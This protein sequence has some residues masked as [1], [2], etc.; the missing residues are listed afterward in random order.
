M[1]ENLRKLEEPSHGCLKIAFLMALESSQRKSRTRDMAKI[2]GRSALGRQAVA[3][4]CPDPLALGATSGTGVDTPLCIPSERE[5]LL[6]FKHHLRD[7]F[8]RLSSWNNASANSDCCHWLGVVCSNVT[9]H[10]AELHLNTTPPDPVDYPFDSE[11]YDKALDVTQVGGEINPCLADLKHLNYLNLSHNFLLGKRK[12]I[13]A[14][15]GTMISLSHL[16][17]SHTEFYGK[18]P[19]QFGNLSNLVYFDLSNVAQGTIPSQIGNVSNLS[20]LNLRGLSL[21]VENVDWLSRLSKLKYLDL[22]GS[23][24]SKAFHWLHTLQAL[25]SLMHLHLSQCTLHVPHDSQPYTLNF[26]SLL[27]LDMSDVYYPFFPKWVLGLTKAFSIELS[28]NNIQGLI[29]D[30]IQNITFLQ[31]LDLSYNSFSSSIPNSLCSL[32][33]LKFLRLQ[34]NILNGSISNVLGN[35]TSLIVLDLSS[36]GQLEGTIPTSL[37][38]QLGPNFPSWILSQNKLQYLEMSNAGIFDSIPSCTNHLSSKLPYLSNDVE[39]L[40]LSS[41]ALS[42]S[43]HEFLC[44][45]QY[46]QM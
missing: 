14:F 30:G 11:G 12:P 13:P 1:R 5:T 41:N 44:K 32:H 23:N 27:T 6:K 7:P 22:R 34:Q 37:E 15:L 29:P 38:W 4:V 9:A 25:P 36:N 18:I 2:V 19:P 16:D 3:S 8:N 45:N 35:L 28:G 24:L 20:Y 46:K 17:L 40:D 10:V 33:H 31:N 21:F 39:Q 26:S 43:M 42:G